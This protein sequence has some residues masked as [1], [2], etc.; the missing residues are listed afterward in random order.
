MKVETEKMLSIGRFARLTGVTV[1]ALRHYDELGLLRPAHVDEWTG[2][3]WYERSQLREAVAVRR[4]RT[5]RV[6]LDEVAVLIHSDDKSL[7]EALA[8]HRARLEGELV[9][10]RQILTELDA[11]I[12]GKEQLVTDVTLDLPLVDEPAGRFAVAA[13][14]VRVDDMFTYVPETIIRVREWLDA[15]HV[16]CIDPPLSIFLGAGIDEWLDV[17]VGWPIG[18]AALEGSD[19]IVVRE[20]PPARAVEHVH[21]GPFEGLPDV[22]RALEP[23]L[24][25]RGFEPLGLAREQYI[26]HPNNT[27]DPADYETRIVWPV[28]T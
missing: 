13:E 27:S 14:R 15:Q 25:E 16:P 11:L 23:A 9:E 4:L 20:L 7:R 18:D 5:L 12:E 26:G 2:Y 24:R 17:E 28:R 21:Y 8:V 6:P 10:T 19:G 22:Y 1:K 3:R